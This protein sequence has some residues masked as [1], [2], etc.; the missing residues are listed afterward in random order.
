MENN[1][2]ALQIQ[3][4]NAKD[5]I[6]ALKDEVL[7]G[8]THLLQPQ[9]QTTE[10]R[11]LTRKEVS[12]LLSISLVTLHTWSKNGTLKAYRIGNKV[13]YKESEV[14]E[15]LQEINAKKG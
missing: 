6:N 9:P 1:I 2:K 12:E 15:A 3:G 4:V 7:S 5:L 8:I 10:N 13:R 14:M 11:L